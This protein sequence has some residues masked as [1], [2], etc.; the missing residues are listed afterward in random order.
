MWSV[1]LVSA[2]AICAIACGGNRSPSPQTPSKEPP[3]ARAETPLPAPTDPLNLG[4]EDVDGV[5]PH[6][7][8]LG[9]GEGPTGAGYEVQL[10][11][12]AHGGA[13]SLRISGAPV[14]TGD[15]AATSRRVDGEAM[16]GKRVRVRGW[17]RTTELTGGWAGFWV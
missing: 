14:N 1:R 11:A 13:H 7:W 6:G 10:D 8:A 2:I 16:R 15:F 9:I 3:A 5:L 4:F 12:D 17:I